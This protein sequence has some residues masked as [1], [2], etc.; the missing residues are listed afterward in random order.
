MLYRERERERERDKILSL[1]LSFLDQDSNQNRTQ[2]EPWQNKKM[3][4]KL[5]VTELKRDQSDTA[6]TMGHVWSY[7]ISM[8]KICCTLIIVWYNFEYYTQMQSC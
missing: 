5:C 1:H 4:K 7:N 8:D 3:F 6:I 2:H